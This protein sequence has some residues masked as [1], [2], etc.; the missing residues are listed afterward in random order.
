MSI[1]D[2]FHCINIVT[3]FIYVVDV[4]E[5]VVRVAIVTLTYPKISHQSILEI[6]PL[7]KGISLLVAV[8]PNWI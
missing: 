1:L 5:P 6:F 4:H 2:R 8:A 7:P 3:Y